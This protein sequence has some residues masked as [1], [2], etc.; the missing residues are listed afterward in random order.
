MP[1][2]TASVIN[3]TGNTN[4]S[5][6]NAN[7]KPMESFGGEI[8]G[9]VNISNSGS[10][11]SGTLVSA[12]NS[13]GEVIANTISEHDGSYLIPSLLNDNYTIKASKVGYQTSEYSQKVTIDLNNSPVIKNVDFSVVTTD[14]ERANNDIPKNFQL[15]AKL[16]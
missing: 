4:I 12:F 7:L 8:A 1:G 15:I 2:K 14:V 3:L 9:S 5:N 16:S 10:T 13:S 6:V 11:L